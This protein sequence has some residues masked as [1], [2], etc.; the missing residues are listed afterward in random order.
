MTLTK[1]ET[2]LTRIITKNLLSTISLDSFVERVGSINGDRN[3]NPPTKRKR[4][5]R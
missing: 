2:L 3:E 4:S 1:L 5:C